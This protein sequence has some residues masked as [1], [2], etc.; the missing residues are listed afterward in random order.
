MSVPQHSAG[1]TEHLLRGG[2][3]ILFLP[4]PESTPRS[5]TLQTGKHHQIQQAPEPDIGI[6]SA[7]LGTCHSLPPFSHQFS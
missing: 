7:S 6:L 3:I 5:Q 2:S 1:R 4:D